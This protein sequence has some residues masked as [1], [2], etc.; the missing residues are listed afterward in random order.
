MKIK[1]FVV[2]AL[3]ALA[4]F[5]SAEARAAAH[6]M[7]HV[8]NGRFVLDGKEYKA[9]GFTAY[10]FNVA[11]WAKYNSRDDMDKVFASAQ[12]HGM[13]MFRVT[14]VIYDFP[15]ADLSKDLSDAVL[16][17]LDMVIELARTHG[18]KVIID[19]ADIPTLTGRHSNPQF[20]FTD[21]ANFDRFKAEYALIPGRV[22]SI[23]GVPYKDDPAIFSWSISGEV[24]PYGLQLNPDGSVNL[25]SLSRD[26]NNWERFVV[27]AAQEIKKYDPNHMISD[28]GMLHISPNGP[29]N[30]ATGKPYWQ[31]VWSNPIFDYCAIHIYPDDKELAKANALPIAPPYAFSF[32]VGQWA[33]LPRYKEFAATLSKPLIVEEWGLQTDKHQPDNPAGQLVYSPRFC[34]DYVTNA[35]DA[36]IANDIPIMILWQW[37]PKEKPDIVGMDRYPGNSPLDDQLIDIMTGKI[38]TILA[39]FR[40][41]HP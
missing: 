2:I 27:R 21:P 29:V 37:H 7:V 3:I 41:R 22:N 24:C 32:P 30:D 11:A 25:N 16:K 14:A 6:S 28:G 23:S 39:S 12:A 38:G 4:A 36:V 35:L 1:L 26:V 5:G 34:I 31:T 8:E 40:A 33:N 17:R 10:Q 19:L 9:V 13:N 15:E 20:D 18:M